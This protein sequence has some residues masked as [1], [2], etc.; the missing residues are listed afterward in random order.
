[1]GLQFH[2]HVQGKWFTIGAIVSSLKSTQHELHRI[3]YP[4]FVHCYLDMIAKKLC[5]EA[6]EFFS[7]HAKEHRR[8]HDSDLRQLALVLRPEHLLTNECARSMLQRKFPIQL[9]LLSFEML[10]AYLCDAQ[11]FI[12]LFILNQRINISVLQNH[13]ELQVQQL[14][15]MEQANTPDAIAQQLSTEATLAANGTT[16]V[17]DEGEMARMVYAA[18][19]NGTETEDL[20]R[21]PILWGVPVRKL[22][23]Q[24]TEDTGEEGDD[25]DLPNGI[26][27]QSTDE[28]A[29]EPEIMDVE[30]VVEQSTQL[31]EQQGPAPDRKDSY[32]VGILE[33]LIL[34]KSNAEKM[35]EF[36]ELRARVQLGKGTLPSALCFTFVNSHRGLNCIEFSKDV[37]LVAGGFAD[38]SIRVWRN[39]N[40]PLGTAI[41]VSKQYPTLSAEQ[42]MG[43]LR[44]HSGPVY[45]CSFS[46]DNRFLLSASA[47]CTVRLWSLATRTNI[48]CYRS[49]R[50]PVWDVKFSPVGYYFATASL[51]R[52]ARLWSTDRIEPLR[53]F[54]GH[55]SDVD[56]VEFHPNC[57][58][59][60]TGSSDRTI[61]LWDIQTGHCVRIF[62]GHFGAIRC[63]AFSPNGRLV[64]SGGQDNFLNVWDLA[65]GSRVATLIGHT[66][67]IHSV[68][69]SQEGAILS[70]GGADATVRLWDMADLTDTSQEKP[71]LALRIHHSL[72]DPTSRAS[73]NLLRTFRTKDTNVYQVAFTKKNLLIVGGCYGFDL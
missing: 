63:L 39:D 48:V 65:T 61:R 71:K 50:Y 72:N 37:T 25:E 11:N 54:A 6:V 66:A 29:A 13:P 33:K 23:T 9:S 16:V 7:S 2:G 1:M 40:Q 70:S 52:T 56:C 5:S 64:C 46:R 10:N 27:P 42:R 34:R 59:L 3:L 62:S 32:N 8:L 26:E 44:G 24:P 20:H 17:E 51:D 58:Y 12:L 55:L 38:S 35:H 22:P 15:E 67:S 31:V 36:E 68:H 4:L 49:H 73:G 60:A 57:N 18:G 28:N 69:F 47:D 43:I 21:H 53:I 14:E 19:Q 30:P 45:A 41:G